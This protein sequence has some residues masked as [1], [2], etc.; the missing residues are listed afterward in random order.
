M[1][2]PL[3]WLMEM[4]RMRFAVVVITLALSGCSTFSTWTE[5]L[6]TVSVPSLNDVKAAGLSVFNTLKNAVPW[7]ETAPSLAAGPNPGRPCPDERCTTLEQVEAKGYSLARNGDIRWVHLV[8]QFYD[9]RRELYPDSR[10]DDSIRVVRACQRD[11]ADLM[12][13]GRLTEAQWNYLIHKM[14]GE[15]EL[16][17]DGFYNTPHPQIDC[18]TSN[19]GPPPPELLNRHA[20]ELV[21]PDLPAPTPR[22]PVGNP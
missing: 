20:I 2:G 15:I 22:R 1:F 16:V 21:R 17:Q 18:L 4:V 6:P 7:G 19:I 11:L 3:V 8:D 10:D 14:R 12:D 5:R 13:R 9:K